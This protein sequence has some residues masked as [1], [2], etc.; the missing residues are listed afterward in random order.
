LFAVVAALHDGMVK[1]L[2]VRFETLSG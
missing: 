1:Y 2:D